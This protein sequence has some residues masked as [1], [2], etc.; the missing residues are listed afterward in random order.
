[1]IIKE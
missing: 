1:V